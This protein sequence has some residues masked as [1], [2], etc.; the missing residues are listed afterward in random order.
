MTCDVGAHHIHMTDVDIGFFDSNARMNPPFRGQRD[1]DAIRLAL[2]DGT[3]DAICSDHTPVDD[4][5]KLLPFGE[6]TPGATGLELLLSLALKWNDDADGG[7]HPG[8]AIAKVTSDAARVAGLPCGQLAVGSVADVCIFDPAVR[9][10][11]EAKAL[12][13]QGKHTPFLGYELRGQVSATI[14]AGQLAYAR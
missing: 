5:E 6:A 1:R 4:D 14:V 12:A 8:R 9:W 10:T 13:S 2:A 11:V 3:I 7:K